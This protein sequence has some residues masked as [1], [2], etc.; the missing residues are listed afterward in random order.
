MTTVT[1]AGPRL[2]PSRRLARKVLLA[3]ATLALLTTAAL[4]MLAIAV[5]TVS[6]ARRLYSEILP[7][8]LSRAILTLWGV[9]VETHQT[10]PFPQTQTVYM[11]NHTSTLD[12][13]VLAG[14]GLPN[15]RFVGAQDVDGFLRWMVPLGIMSWLMGTLW[16][17][18]PSQPA[19]R[20][21]WFQRTERLLRRTGDSVY[22]SPEGERVTTGR[23]GPFNQDNF[24]LAASLGAP[25]VPIYIDIPRKIDPGKGFDALP[26]TVHAYIRP[27]IS[28]RGWTLENL[29]SNT[30][31]VRDLF[32]RIQTQLRA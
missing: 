30:Q 32:V 11:S 23:L 13:F 6:R 18:P 29:E 31:M 14:A 2:S 12:M 5:V 4:I 24:H 7:R 15:T 26:G 27:A 20:A 8:Q 21:R 25:I 3:T 10:E 19:E 1:K 17:P 9:R 28:T 22:L 16:A